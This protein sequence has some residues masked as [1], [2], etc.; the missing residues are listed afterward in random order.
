[1]KKGKP[2]IDRLAIGIPYEDKGN[3]E[4]YSDVDKHC[5]GNIWRIGYKTIKSRDEKPH[6]HRY[7]EQLVRDIILLS[8]LKEGSWIL[9]PFVG[10]GTTLIASNRRGMNSIGFEIDKRRFKSA[11]KRVK[12]YLE[13]EDFTPIVMEDSG[14]KG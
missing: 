14:D 5:R 10:S 7:P 1:M 13:R 11:Q 2:K 12:S 8:R 6:P 3:V 4:R 9:D